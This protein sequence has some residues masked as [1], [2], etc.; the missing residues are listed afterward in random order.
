[1]QKPPCIGI[2][3]NGNRNIDYCFG[4]Q[5]P[6]GGRNPNLVGCQHMG[7]EIAFHVGVYRLGKWINLG[8]DFLFDK[9]LM[10]N[11]VREAKKNFPGCPFMNPEIATGFIGFWP[12]IINP[13]TDDRLS[14]YPPV[15]GR[16]DPEMIKLGMRL[17]GPPP[18]PFGEEYPI[19]TDTNF[20]LEIID[21]VY[22][23]TIPNDIK[24]GLEKSYEEICWQAVVYFD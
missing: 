8:G 6:R 3:K 14:I 4:V 20:F 13:N 2:D 17:S 16:R 11:G 22:G 7:L 21:E 15:M 9:R 24:I 19:F 12:Q 10:Q 1:M 5:N 23:K 18:T